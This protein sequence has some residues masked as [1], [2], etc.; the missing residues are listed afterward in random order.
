MSQVLAVRNTLAFRE[1]KK[2]FN[3]GKLKTLL[4]LMSMGLLISFLS[5]MMLVNFN[6]V[7]TKGYTIKY[8]E[9]QQQGL[10]E[11]NEI[12]KKDLLEKK[13][14]TQLSVTEKANSM[15][16][17]RDIMYVRGHTALALNDSI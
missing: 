11:E 4:I 17:P 9:V 3:P 2:S 5:V 1:R 10:Y 13:A 15:I 14:L 16:R 8:L 7:S 12:L 6:H